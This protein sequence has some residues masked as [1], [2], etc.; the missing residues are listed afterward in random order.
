MGDPSKK[1]QAEL[2]NDVHIVATL[3]EHACDKWGREAVDRDLTRLW[4]L[5]CMWGMHKIL[6]FGS[7][8]FRNLGEL[9][10]IAKTVCG[11]GL[12]ACGGEPPDQ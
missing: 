12:H 7:T 3:Y 5:R 2:R 11:L 8:C 6:P 4:D 10:W 9:L 1:R